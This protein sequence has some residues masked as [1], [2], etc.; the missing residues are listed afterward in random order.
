MSEVVNQ[1]WSPASMSVTLFVTS[2]PV[3]VLSTTVTGQTAVPLAWL[4]PCHILISTSGLVPP[5]T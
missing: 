4:V 1:I 2:C 3:V 5:N